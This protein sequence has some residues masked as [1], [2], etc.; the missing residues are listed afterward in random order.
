MKWAVV[1]SSDLA[2]SNNWGAQYHILHVTHK[3]AVDELL[4]KFTTKE[5]I[6]LAENLP[7]DQ[8]AANAILSRNHKVSRSDLLECFVPSKPD[9]AI[10]FAWFEKPVKDRP[11]L[12]RELRSRRIKMAVYCAAAAQ[13]AK[14]KI[15]EELL[16]ITKQKLAVVKRLHD[17]HTLAKS[18]GAKALQKAL[19]RDPG[20]KG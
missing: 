9:K 1:S 6:A 20:K 16:E 3:P 10:E 15:A 13:F 8:E 12:P 11:E 4:E 5:L 17:I 18:K 14:N 7:F 2:A 19:T